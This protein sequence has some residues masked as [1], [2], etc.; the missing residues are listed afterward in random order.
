[1]GTRARTQTWLLLR[2]HEEQNPADHDCSDAGPHRHVDGLLLLDRKLERPE[3]RL[4]CPPGV[5][6]AAVREREDAGRE[7]EEGD[8]FEPV[9]PNA[10]L[11]KAWRSPSRGPRHDCL[12]DMPRR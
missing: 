8:A 10:S 6:E 3:L 4:V 12:P 7:Q 11:R 5:R 9:H 1:M 2:T